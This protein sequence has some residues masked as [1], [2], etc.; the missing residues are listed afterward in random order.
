MC[1][2]IAIYH[3]KGEV[4]SIFGKIKD[5]VK[6]TGK[7]IKKGAVAVGSKTAEVGKDIGH[8]TKEIFVDDKPKPTGK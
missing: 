1:Y 7:D 3:A 5:I 4:M 8:G 2:C 6:G